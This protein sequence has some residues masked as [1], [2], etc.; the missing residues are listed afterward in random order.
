MST[1]CSYCG[2]ECHNELGLQ[3][4]DRMYGRY[5]AECNVC[6]ESWNGHVRRFSHT[7]CVLRDCSEGDRP[8]F[9]SN[10][11]FLRHFNKYHAS[12]RGRVEDVDDEYGGYTSDYAK[13]QDNLTRKRYIS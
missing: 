12:R 7:Q 9:A 4:H 13:E 6:H 3:Q 5:C 2:V 11:E 8:H 10:E 1:E